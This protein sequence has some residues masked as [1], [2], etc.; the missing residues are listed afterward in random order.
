M[1]NL[2]NAPSNSRSRAPKII[3]VLCCFT[4]FVFF[5]LVPEGHLENR[6]EDE[7]TLKEQQEGRK[8]MVFDATMYGILLYGPGTA[9]LL[10]MSSARQ[11]IGLELLMG[12][13]TFWGALKATENYR[14]G[15][16]RTKLIQWANYAGTLYGFGIPIF[17]ESENDKAYLASA[18]LA[19]PLSGLIA[20]SLSDHRW[21][22]KGE[23]D[24]L[25]NG[26]L[27]G[28]LYGIA[29]P[30][31]LDIENL[32]NWTQAKIYTA[33]AMIGVPTGVWATS[34]LFRDKSI[35]QGRAH[36]ISLGGVV[37]S[38]Y[39]AGVT[40]V[41]GLGDITIESGEIETVERPRAYV[42]A[43]AL[44]LPLGT[45][46]GYKLTDGD[47]YTVGRARLI[48]LGAVVGA[49][50]GSG[51]LMLADVNGE[52]TK[53]YVLANM[54]GSAAGMWYAHRFTRGWGEE[55]SSA[56]DVHV[57]PEADEIFSLELIR[58]SF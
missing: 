5:S 55:L 45:Y 54:V 27:V 14:L 51:V 6:S 46:L 44:G 8:R 23:S 50:S 32:E 43:S 41:T 25:T 52:N 17:F 10:E 16:G 21:F 15:A 1:K 7:V 35:S 24:L 56:E 58:L 33:S 12:G 2:T 57:Q 36:L 49:L 38:L 34:R 13:G 37:G 47:E 20:H 19:T 3:T 9:R 48:I 22:E 28:G 4:S 30:Y 42:L 11:I 18:M 26:G 29:I 40:H 39:A 31:L 53:S